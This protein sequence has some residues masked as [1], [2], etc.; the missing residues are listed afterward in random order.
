MQVS[1]LKNE[2]YLRMNCIVSPPQNYANQY[3]IILLF[4]TL[5]SYNLIK[6]SYS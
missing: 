2:Y 5:K 1:L 3:L 4:Y 6:H